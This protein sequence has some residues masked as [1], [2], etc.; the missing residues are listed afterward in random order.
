M[1]ISP[2]VT[3]AWS[4]PSAKAA[5]LET[6][7]TP[8]V[9]APAATMPFFKNDRRLLRPL[10]TVPSFFISFSFSRVASSVPNGRSHTRTP[11]R[12][13]L[14]NAISPSPA[15]TV[16]LSG[17]RVSQR[18]QVAVSR[19]HYLCPCKTAG[20]S[21][22][23]ALRRNV[24]SVNFQ[25]RAFAVQIRGVIAGGDF[26]LFSWQQRKIIVRP[27]N[28]RQILSA[29]SFCN[30]QMHHE[31]DA[32]ARIAHGH[33]DTCLAALLFP[34]SLNLQLHFGQRVQAGQIAEIRL[35]RI[36]RVFFVLPI[37]NIRLRR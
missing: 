2:L 6:S 25:D 22:T 15:F 35:R 12:A 29:F 36:H 28:G 1:A 26:A 4:S 7:P 34:R 32:A 10:N 20:L 14:G 9:I 13:T 31:R 30:A 24:I 21:H 33:A 11:A 3:G 37:Q 16:G 17:M 8:A 19:A 5:G 27:E 18:S 23:S